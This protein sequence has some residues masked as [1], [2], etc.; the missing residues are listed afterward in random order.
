MD[1]GCG[2]CIKKFVDS[3][4]DGTPLDLLMD[5]LKEQFVRGTKGNENVIIDILNEYVTSGHKDY[6]AYQNFCEL[7]YSRNL[8]EMN[9][10]FEAIILCWLPGQESPIHNHSSQNCWF[11]VLEGNMEEI[12][13]SF[14]EESKEISQIGEPHV[15]REGQVSWIYD[16]LALHKVKPFGGAGCTLHIYSKPIPQCNLYDPK[17]GTVTVRKLGF[18]TVNKKLTQ[19]E[20][21]CIPY[22]KLYERLAKIENVK[23]DL[24][25][26]NLLSIHA[27]VNEKE[28]NQQ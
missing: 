15:Y 11:A 19:G 3:G 20:E 27:P 18:Y 16:D 14:N 21:G 4:D 5:K 25:Y 23:G 13:Y 7:K 8:V 28:R 24:S 2:G 9:P 17:T 1:G 6:K 12:Y 22:S 10:D 26:L